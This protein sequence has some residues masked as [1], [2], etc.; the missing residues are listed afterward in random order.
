MPL[1]VVRAKDVDCELVVHGFR[2]KRVNQGQYDA[3]SIAVV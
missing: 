1:L 3:D 2:Q